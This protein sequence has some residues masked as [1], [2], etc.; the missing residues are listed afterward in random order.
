M[1][2]ILPLLLVAVFGI[3][4]LVIVGFAYNWVSFEKPLG[5]QPVAFPHDIHA[6]SGLGYLSDGTQVGQLNLPCVQCHLYVEKS[7]FATV[8][9][10]QVCKN[11]HQ[12]LPARTPEQQKLKVYLDNNEAIPWVKIH[13]VPKHVYFSHKRHIKAGVQCESCH[14]DMTVVKT[15]TRVRSFEMGFCVSCHRANN[16]PQDCWT[17][18][19]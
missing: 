11:C 5:V 17:C 18:H 7:R 9:P 2:I 19:H 1:R 12:N 13:N 15:V 8:P 14:G 3:F 10:M 4:A 16:A 6:G